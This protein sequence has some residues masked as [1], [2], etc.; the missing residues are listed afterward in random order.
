MADHITTIRE[1][2]HDGLEY[3]GHE[4]DDV[5]GRV[6]AISEQAKLYERGM[7]AADA[8]E[9]ELADLRAEKAEIVGYAD[10]ASALIDRCEDAERRLREATDANARL[11]KVLRVARLIIADTVQPAT[12]ERDDVLDRIDAALAA[13][14]GTAADDA[15]TQSLC[16]DAADLREEDLRIETYRARGI[17]NQTVTEPVNPAVR[18]EHIPTGIMVACQEH[19]SLLANKEQALRELA[20]KVE[21][22]A[23]AASQ[24]GITPDIPCVKPGGKPEGTAATPGEEKCPNHYCHDGWVGR[25][26]NASGGAPAFPCRHEKCPHRRV[27]ADPRETT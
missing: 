10:G 20:A 19:P 4:L 9:R 1:A 17:T 12:Y 16:H 25:G 7:V 15:M 21:G 27:S 24:S 23:A 22:T 14:E 6:H 18:I 26:D 8:V 2:L 5:T 11:E 13:V 3:H